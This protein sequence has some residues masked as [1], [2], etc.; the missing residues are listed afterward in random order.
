M[1]IGWICAVVALALAAAILLLKW[2]L[3]RASLREVSRE[4]AEKLRTDT[5]TLISLSSGDRAVRALAAQMNI[6]LQAL[7]RERLRLQKGDAELKNAITNVS[8]DLR[9]PLTAICGYLELL[10]KEE[11]SEKARRYLAVIRERSQAMRDL[12]EELFRYSMAAAAAEEMTRQPVSV[13]DVLEQ[14]LAGFYG[15]LTEKGIS[16]EI[17]LP[18]G[19]VTRNLDPAA[20][21]RIFDNLLNNA[22]K[23][24]DGDLRVSLTEAG[25]AVFSNAAGKLDCV[26]TQR[27]FD[28]FYTVE[29][30]SGSTGLG[31]SIAHMLVEKMGGEIGAEYVSGRLR[32]FVRFPEAA[33]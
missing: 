31:L 19:P 27:L 2:A 1:E 26:Q 3:L 14:S 25:E 5:N 23:Y 10:E 9:T 6:Q 13:K 24:S 29:T 11:H 4:L 16:P 30:A 32:I 21:R 7:R 8:H 33:R 28:R 22:L 12:T 18:N 15:S 20:L 17:R